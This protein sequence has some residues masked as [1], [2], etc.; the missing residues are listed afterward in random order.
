[1]AIAKKALDRISRGLKRYSE[2]LGAA[3][4]RDISESDTVV[5]VGDMMADILGYEKYVEISTQFAVKGTVSPST[6]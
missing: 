3:K 5:I 6:T 2:I 1:M 4:K